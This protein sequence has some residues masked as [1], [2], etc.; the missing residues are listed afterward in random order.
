MWSVPPNRAGTPRCGVLGS[1]DSSP[2]IGALCVLCIAPP[3]TPAEQRPSLRI[4]NQARL[5]P[6]PA[7]SFAVRLDDPFGKIVVGKPCR[8]VQRLASRSRGEIGLARFVVPWAARLSLGL[9][10]EGRFVFQ[11]PL[12]SCGANLP[13]FF[14]CQ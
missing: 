14:S 4:G 8:L 2:T 12:G 10:M 7:P 6:M 11:D 13:H 9:G 1:P 3:S 5:S